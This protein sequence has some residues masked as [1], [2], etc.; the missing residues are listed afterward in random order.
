M[1]KTVFVVYTKCGQ[2]IHAVR[3]RKKT[4]NYKIA[5]QVLECVQ[6][7]WVR[8]HMTIR[9]NLQLVSH[10]RFS[11]FIYI[12]STKMLHF[13]HFFL[14]FVFLCL[15]LLQVY[16]SLSE[17]N[18]SAKGF[19]KDFF[20]AKRVEQCS[21]N[22]INYVGTDATDIFSVN[23]IMPKLYW[24]LF[25][26]VCISD[27]TTRL[28]RLNEKRKIPSWSLHIYLKRQRTNLRFRSI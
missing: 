12:L 22:A 7:P 21:R 19:K 9:L 2:N 1:V 24:V 27:A 18:I 28:I 20:L 5:Q 13:S 3:R 6:H 17:S 8:W 14:L 10:S 16:I 25:Q 26:F 23:V 15:L 4:R 11:L